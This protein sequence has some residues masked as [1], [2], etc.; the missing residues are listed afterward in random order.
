MKNN[1][2]PDFDE[3]A[4]EVSQYLMLVKNLEQGTIQLSFGVDCKKRIKK[5]DSEL[6]KTLKATGFLLLYNLIESTIRSAIEGIFDELNK[7]EVSFDLMRNEIKRIIIKNIKNNKSDSLIISIKRIAVDI[8]S[9]S[10]DKGKLFSGNLD[11]KKIKETAKM[12]GFSCKTNSR[13]TRD[14]IDLITIKNH[15]NDLAHGFKSFKEVG[16]DISADELLEIKKKV[17][18]YLKEILQNIEE[19]LAN[20]EY[21][22][23]SE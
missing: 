17:V 22:D 11:A 2:F 13:K 19:Y 15:R 7:K 18:S 8:I 20:E 9:A 10:F 12:Y 5:I 23:S 4:R 3:R 1:L 14:G 21:L 16:K 6:E